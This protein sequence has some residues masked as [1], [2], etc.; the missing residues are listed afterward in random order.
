MNA[1][2]RTRDIDDLLEEWLGLDV[3]TVGT[4]AVDRA[5]HERLKATGLIDPAAYA[6]KARGDTAER[7]LLVE[8]VIV[9]ESWFF[10]DRQ[11]FEFVADVAA[12][13]AAVPGRRPVRIICAPSASGE[14]PYS[15]A[16]ALFDAGLTAEQ[17]AIDAIDI[18]RRSLARAAEG[19]YSANAFRNAD[20]AFRDR[21]FAAE[22]GQ[23]VIDR[24][25][26]DQVRFA[27]ANLLDPVFAD[28][29]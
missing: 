12:T 4:A 16:M 11:V 27:W 20:L 29:R 25:I 14:E 15:L 5:V 26:R 22:A 13:R 7:D 21:W 2:P 10:R 6:R 3:S 9:A 19:R 23:A 17:F 1:T 18:S 28:G 24:R 8:G